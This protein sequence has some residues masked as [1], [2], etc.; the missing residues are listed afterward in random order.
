[1]ACVQAMAAQFAGA[2]RAS[3]PLRGQ[4]PPGLA[5]G[6]ESLL[7]PNRGLSLFHSVLLP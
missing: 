7:Y 4:P 2:Q 5:D 1:M 3:R 6:V